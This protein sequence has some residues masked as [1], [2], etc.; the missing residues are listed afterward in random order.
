MKTEDAENK[1]GSYCLYSSHLSVAN[2]TLEY[3]NTLLIFNL[4]L[5]G[6]ATKGYVSFEYPAAVVRNSIILWDIKLCSLLEFNLRFGGKYSLHLQS[7]KINRAK[8]KC[9][10]RWKI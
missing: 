8:Y 4:A 1:E 7:R 2:F 9:E 5:L 10:S 3:I 6:W